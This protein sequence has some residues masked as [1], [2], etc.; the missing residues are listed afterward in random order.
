M[1]ANTV[2][3][4]IRRLLR[5][6]Q[7][8]QRKI[9]SRLGVSRGTVNSIATGHIRYATVTTEYD[10]VLSD[11]APFHSAYYQVRMPSGQPVM[12]PAGRT[13]SV[14]TDITNWNLPAGAKGMVH[15]EGSATKRRL[16]ITRHGSSHLRKLRRRG[17]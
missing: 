7:Y 4:E 1:I 9:A 6:K 16:K 13:V 2:I 10:V 14:Y 17:R 5:E 12:V 3:K 15:V 8:S 11:L